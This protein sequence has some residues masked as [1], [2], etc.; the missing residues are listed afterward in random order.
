MGPRLSRRSDGG[1][2]NVRRTS[3]TRCWRRI[4]RSRRRFALGGSVATDTVAQLFENPGISGANIVAREAALR[5]SIQDAGVRPEYQERAAE[6]L[7]LGGFSVEEYESRKLNVGVGQQLPFLVGIGG[8]SGAGREA[9]PRATAF[10]PRP[11][12]VWRLGQARRGQIIH[13]AL[14][15]NVPR[16]Y[17]IVD[18][19]DTGGTIVSIKSINLGDATYLRASSL[20]RQVR[21]FVDQIAGF[22]NR[23]HSGYLIRGEINTRV[24][25]LVVPYSPNGSQ[26]IVIERVAR[27]AETRGVLLNVVVFR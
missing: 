16:N 27:Y 10:L 15:Q 2:Q 25:D 7:Y 4:H 9:A 17:P 8:G 5:A 20:K 23:S 21:G 3:R 24:V 22:N 14:G 11:K 19:V 26:R 18:R 1:C 13:A 6:I 12:S